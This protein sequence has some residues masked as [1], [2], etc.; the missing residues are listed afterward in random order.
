MIDYEGMSPGA[1]KKTK[2]LI[3]NIK[4]AVTKNAITNK[5]FFTYS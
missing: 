1:T 5:G 3:Y 2:K 4:K